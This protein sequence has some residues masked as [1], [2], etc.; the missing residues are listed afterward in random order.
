V[1]S[2]GVTFFAHCVAAHA[3]LHTSSVQMQPLRALVYFVRPVANCC[4]HGTHVPGGGAA[5]STPLSVVAFVALLLDDEP[6]A[7]TNKT[8]AAARMLAG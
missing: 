5:A 4:E 8:I 2:A 3:S 7:T 6:H 1:G